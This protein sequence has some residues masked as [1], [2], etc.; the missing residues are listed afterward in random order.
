MSDYPEDWQAQG[1][2]CRECAMLAWNSMSPEMRSLFS[3][4]TISNDQEDR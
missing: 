4:T 2:C 3:S 1:W